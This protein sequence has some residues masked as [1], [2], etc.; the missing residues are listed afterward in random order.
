LCI[1]RFT[2]QL[3]EVVEVTPPGPRALLLR[4]HYRP[5]A[6]HELAVSDELREQGGQWQVCG[7]WHTHPSGIGG[8]SPADLRAEAHYRLGF[9]GEHD[10][11]LAI[12]LARPDAEWEITA[13]RVQTLMSGRPVVQPLAT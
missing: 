7:T 1:G 6:V 8:M 13:F 9:V 3:V 10:P 2:P 12:V 5:D 4:D 11:W